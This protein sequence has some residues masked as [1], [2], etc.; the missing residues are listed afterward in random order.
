MKKLGFDEMENL[1]AGWPSWLGGANVSTFCEDY[2]MP[3]DGHW[4]FRRETTT[5]YL[6]GLV[7]NTSVQTG[8]GKC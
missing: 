3:D 8:M 5:S 4:E 6:W 7:S 2:S 1:E